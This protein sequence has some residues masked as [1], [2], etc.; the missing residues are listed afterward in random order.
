MVRQNKREEGF[1]PWVPVHMPATARS[2]GAWPSVWVSCMGGY[3]GPGMG[4]IIVA[5]ARSWTGNIRVRTRTRHSPKA[6]SPRVV[7]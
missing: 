7:I 5:L 1:I 6:C 4:A 3:G 2:G